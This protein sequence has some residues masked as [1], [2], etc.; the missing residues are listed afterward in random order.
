[1]SSLALCSPSNWSLKWEHRISSRWFLWS[2]LLQTSAQ[3]ERYNALSC[4]ENPTFWLKFQAGADLPTVPV[5]FGSSCGVCFTHLQP[6]GSHFCL[7]HHMQS[8]FWYNEIPLFFS[9]THRWGFS[10]NCH[11]QTLSSIVSLS[12][13]ISCYIML[14]L[15]LFTHFTLNW[16]DSLVL[17]FP[18]AP[19]AC[20]SPTSS[21][22]SPRS[23][24]PPLCCAARSRPGSAGSSRAARRRSRR[25][26]DCRGRPRPHGGAWPSDWPHRSRSS[27]VSLRRFMKMMFFML[28]SRYIKCH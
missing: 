22:A 16:L 13:S 15:Y 11:I 9:L 14:Y 2:V 12:Y 10:I 7:L 23:S 19:V 17:A 27:L 6:K 18:P 1:M 8:F 20:V 3:A 4:E 21:A 5:G 28:L 26:G 24:E 25:A